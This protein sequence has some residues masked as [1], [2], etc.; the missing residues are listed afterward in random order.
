[1]DQVRLLQTQ[2]L[3]QRCAREPGILSL[4]SGSIISP[5]VPV[6]KITT[7]NSTVTFNLKVGEAGY[8]GS[9]QH[10]GGDHHIGQLC[11]AMVKHVRTAL[12]QGHNYT[13]T[14]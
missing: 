7:R 9:S 1:M 10:H 6:A 8:G 14:S 2:I 13:V 5:A 4:S 3:R 12:L 11:D